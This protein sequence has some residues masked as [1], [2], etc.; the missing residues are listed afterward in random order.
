[1]APPACWKTHSLKI[2]A[3]LSLLLFAAVQLNR[4]LYFPP[5]SDDAWMAVVAKN[6]ALGYGWASSR[7]G[8]FLLDPMIT[9][10]PGLL[11]WVALGIHAFGNQVWVPHVMAYAL[12]LGL[13]AIWL[14]RVRPYVEARQWYAMLLLLPL[15]FAR[16]DAHM[17]IVCQG[18]F[19]TF[20]YLALSTTLLFE[21]M[22]HKRIS[23]ALWA[24]LLAGFALVTKTIALVALTGLAAAVLLLLWAHVPWRAKSWQVI[25]GF[26]AIAVLPPLAWQLYQVQVM[27]GMDA[28]MVAELGR[29]GEHVFIRTGSGI[30]VLMHA[31]ERGALLPQLWATA[32][33]NVMAY[34]NPVLSNPVATSWLFPLVL[35][36][37]PALLVLAWRN[38]GTSQARLLMLL[39]WSAMAYLGWALVIG[40]VHFGRFIAI[41]LFLGMLPAVVALARYR[42]PFWMVTVVMLLGCVLV[43]PSDILF[44]GRVYGAKPLPGKE[45]ESLEQIYRLV[46]EQYPDRQLASCT[47]V[48]VYEM[49]YLMPEA[50]TVSDC[51]YLLGK[52]MQFDA[53]QF[54]A[55]NALP[56]DMGEEDALRYFVEEKNRRPAGD[57]VA[58]VQWAEPV[59]FLVIINPMG[60]Y[61]KAFGYEPIVYTPLREHCRTIMDDG[62][63]A[64]QDCRFED[65]QKAMDA[66]GGV[67]FYP[68]QWGEWKR[69]YQ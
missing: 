24:G 57:M 14:W 67:W 52:S 11:A 32:K 62:F 53:R 15:V 39:I 61:L 33:H 35:L 37:L 66:R 8:I 10:G 65:L 19:T 5:Y 48:V 31:M 18:D 44:S 13:F 54:I 51:L 3:W 45:R 38:C 42:K 17:W 22:E 23:L 43:P 1:M 68:P 7:E 20:L 40:K 64:L 6:W 50:G 12:N 30:D 16:N 47:A 2:A 25:A 29:Y 58:P 34:M 27:A 55:G 41:G 69:F 63:Y 4:A 60:H 46:R 9:T 59:D 21:A 49:D 28:A 56:Q 26:V 36:S